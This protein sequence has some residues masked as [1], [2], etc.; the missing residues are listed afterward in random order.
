MFLN[1]LGIAGSILIILLALLGLA[2]IIV[3]AIMYLKPDLFVP[4]KKERKQRKPR[5]VNKAVTKDKVV[6]NVKVK[7]AE[8][9]KPGRKPGRKAVKK[10]V[11]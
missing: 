5:A 7:E 6:K 3:G 4:K 10:Q 11:A 8:S 9:K 1:V 2:V